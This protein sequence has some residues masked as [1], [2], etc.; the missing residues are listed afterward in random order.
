MTVTEMRQ[1]PIQLAF[2]VSTNHA[3]SPINPKLFLALFPLLIFP[4]CTS[5]K[6]WND[7]RLHAL[8]LRRRKPSLSTLF[9]ALST[10]IRPTHPRTVLPPIVPGPH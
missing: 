7:H 10:S 2:S 9:Q 3:R 6:L 5:I 8:T 4:Y 1:L